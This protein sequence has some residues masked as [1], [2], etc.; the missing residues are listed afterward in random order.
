MQINATQDRG[1]YNTIRIIKPTKLRAD[2][3]Y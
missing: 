3:N 2:N 1:A